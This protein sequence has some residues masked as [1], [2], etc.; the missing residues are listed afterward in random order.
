MANGDGGSRTLAAGC[1]GTSGNLSA[2]AF[3]SV[4]LVLKVLR[5]GFALVIGRIVCSRT[6]ISISPVPIGQA[7]KGSLRYVSARAEGGNMAGNFFEIT[8]L[9]KKR[10]LA[11][12]VGALVI[13]ISMGLVIWTALAMPMQ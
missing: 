5:S 12:V 3:L 7:F 11:Y 10:D 8:I 2:P 9:G 1:G 4:T 13:V 6:Q